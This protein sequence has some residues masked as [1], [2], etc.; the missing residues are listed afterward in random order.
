[1]GTVIWTCVAVIAAFA[2]SFLGGLAVQAIRK[3]R[4]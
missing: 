1:M 4:R 3:R 2:I